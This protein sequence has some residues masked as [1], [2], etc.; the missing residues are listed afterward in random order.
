MCF[1][2][3]APKESQVVFFL[4]IEAGQNEAAFHDDISVLRSPA[5]VNI[6]SQAYCKYT[7]CIK[8]LYRH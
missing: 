2:V 3:E 6:P 4:E 5:S 7:G 8:S 1:W